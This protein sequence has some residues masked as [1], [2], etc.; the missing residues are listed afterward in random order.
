MSVVEQ[1]P[2]DVTHE[3]SR[4]NI[5]NLLGAIRLG[6]CPILVYLALSQQPGAFAVLLVF[7]LMTDWFDGKIAILF[8]QQTTFG[9][10][11][12]SIADTTLYTTLVLGAVWMKWEVLQGEVA[13][14]VAAAV[15][16]AVTCVTTLFRFGRLPSYH[17][18]AAKTSWFLVTVASVSLF[19]DW[20]LLP[21]RIT[22]AAAVL[23]NLEQTAMT[24]ILS[25]WRADVPSI[26][27]AWRLEQ[28]A[29]PDA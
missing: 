17:T 18:R 3:P 20:S 19:A 29:D 1:P 5:P 26:Y 4:W 2:N 8:K 12:D 25:E 28:A 14:L 23:T 27:H 16:Y 15:G 13:W 6:G 7:L 21:L 10:R 22:A 24:F 9:A 11:L